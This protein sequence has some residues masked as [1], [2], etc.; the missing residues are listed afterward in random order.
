MA[1][2]LA[3]SS[4]VMVVD[5][6]SVTPD[7]PLREMRKVALLSVSSSRSASAME[8]AAVSGSSSVM[9]VV[10][11]PVPVFVVPVPPPATVMATVNTLSACDIV[12]ATLA[13][14]KLCAV[15]WFIVVK[16]SVPLVAPLKSAAA[17]ST[18]LASESVPMVHCTVISAVGAVP[19]TLT[20]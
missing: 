1:V 20:L 2:P 17:A 5:S 13:R 4:Q 15:A 16:V 9:E 8:S 11:V 10:T 14:A 7:A 6:P 3:A 19:V 18:V 12:L